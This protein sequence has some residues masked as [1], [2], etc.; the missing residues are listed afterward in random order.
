MSL[1][2]VMK[3]HGFRLSAS[4]AGQAWY[5]KFIDYDGRRAYIAVTD[6]DEEGLPQSLDEPVVV[7][8]YDM[9]SGDELERRQ[10]T[11]SLKAYLESL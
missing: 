7:V 10:E 11:G 6:K 3:D 4:C 8:I 5:T 2:E 1:E 9:R